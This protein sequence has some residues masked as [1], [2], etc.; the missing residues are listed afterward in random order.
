DG[1]RDTRSDHDRGAHPRGPEPPEGAGVRG[2]HA[3]APPERRWG[4]GTTR[5][6][7]VRG[8]CLGDPER[9]AR[10]GAIAVVS[11]RRGPRRCFL[12]VLPPL[13]AAVAPAPARALPDPTKP[14]PFA[15]GVT[16]LTFTKPSVTTGAPRPLDTVVWYPAV[17]GS[18]TATPLGRRDATVLRRRSP[19]LLF[20]HGLCGFPEQS[21][22]LTAALASWGF[23]V[24]APPHPGN[25]LT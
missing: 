11:R 4:R 6:G 23:V 18:G 1:G 22:F 13:A 19:L 25:R 17:P 15:V 2:A 10:A 12:L 20:S 14:G 24:A 16:N 7:L 9:A 3:R 21:V 5:P 8:P